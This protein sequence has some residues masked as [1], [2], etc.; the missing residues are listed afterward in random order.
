M[1]C[2][3]SARR[4][5]HHH[6]NDPST[7][8]SP[9]PIGAKVRATQT[10][11]QKVNCTRLDRPHGVST[12]HVEATYRRFS[13]LSFLC[14]QCYMSGC[15]GYAGFAAPILGGG[16]SMISWRVRPNASFASRDMVYD[17]WVPASMV[18]RGRQAALGGERD[19]RYK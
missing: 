16:K 14:H 15:L 19:L 2:S 9:A 3:G 13:V 12:A 6:A 11:Y 5:D 8:F 1:L 10:K 4:R 17:D 7:Q 18:E